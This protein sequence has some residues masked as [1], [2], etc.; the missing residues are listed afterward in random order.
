MSFSHTSTPNGS[1]FGNNHNHFNLS[2]IGVKCYG[3]Q[4]TFLLRIPDHR[5]PLAILLHSLAAAAV[6]EELQFDEI[7]D[8]RET[9]SCGIVQPVNNI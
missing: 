9:I 6:P 7:G 1:H 4:H 8:G 3:K 2:K 5:D